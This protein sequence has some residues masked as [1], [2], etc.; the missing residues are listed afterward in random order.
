MGT[1]SNKKNAF[2][3]FVSDDPI[4]EHLGISIYTKDSITEYVNIQANRYELEKFTGKK[5]D[6]KK[7]L[8][9][10]LGDGDK[11]EKKYLKFD[12]VNEAYKIQ[13][14]NSSIPTLLDD[15]E[16]LQI[17]TVNFWEKEKELE[18]IFAIQNSASGCLTIQYKD[19]DV[20]PLNS[21]NDITTTSTRVF[22]QF[23][24]T[25]KNANILAQ[26]SPVIVDTPKKSDGGS[27][28]YRLTVDEQAS[29]IGGFYPPIEGY[30]E[31]NQV[32]GKLR[33]HFNRSL[34]MWESG[35]QQILARLLTD[36]DPAPVTAIDIDSIDNA[37]ASDFYGD[38]AEYGLSGFTVGAALPLSVHNGNPYTF[39]PHVNVS[40]DSQGDPQK[41]KDKIRVVNRAPRAFK[42]NSVVLCSL[43]DSE[44]I[45]Q[46]FGDIEEVDK[47]AGVGG[48]QFCKFFISSDAYFQPDLQ[49]AL[50]YAEEANL[51]QTLDTVSRLSTSVISSFAYE[52]NFRLRFYWDLRSGASEGDSFGGGAKLENIPEIFT[53]LEKDFDRLARLNF[54]IE[55]NAQL[56]LEG[57]DSW[58]E[59]DHIITN[60]LNSEVFTSTIFDQVTPRMG[61]TGAA[62]VLARTNPYQG[63]SPTDSV[64][65]IDTGEITSFWGPGFPDGYNTTQI[66]R[67]NNLPGNFSI[68]YS[69]SNAYQNAELTSETAGSEYYANNPKP[70]WSY[71]DTYFTEGSQIKN[72]KEESI[73]AN[74]L[75]M[76]S[77]SSDKN[78][79]QLPAEIACNGPFGEGV[80]SPVEDFSSL[81]WLLNGEL[82]PENRNIINS[83]GAYL[84]NAY[85]Y[86]WLSNDNDN[87]PESKAYGLEPISPRSIFF[88]FCQ[89]EFAL[90]ADEASRESNLVKVRKGNFYDIYRSHL[91]DTEA[92]HF[93]GKMFERSTGKTNP[94]RNLN[95]IYKDASIQSETPNYGCRTIRAGDPTLEYEA[96]EA[97]YSIDFFNE[98]LDSPFFGS[99][100]QGVIGAKNTIT[101][102]NGGDI[103]LIVTSMFGIAPLARS[104]GGSGPSLSIIPL[105]GGIPIFTPPTPPITTSIKYWGNSPFDRIEYF[106]TAAAYL[107]VHEYWPKEQTLWDPRYFAILHFNAGP[108]FSSAATETVGNAVD[109]TNFLRSVDK[110]TFDIDIRTPTY[111]AIVTENE[112][113][114]IDIDSSQDNTIIPVGTTLSS[115]SSVRPVSEWRIDPIRRGMCLPFRYEY[116]TIGYNNISEILNAGVGFSVNDEVEVGTA[117]FTITEVN[118]EGGITGLAFKQNEDGF[119]ERGYNINPSI[120]SDIHPDENNDEIGSLVTIRNSNTEGE[121][122]EIFIK[123]CVVYTRIAVDAGPKRDLH[124]SRIIP[125]SNFGQSR[126][127]D[128]RTV[129]LSLDKVDSGAYDLF[130]H[131]S[132]DVGIN[133]G[134]EEQTATRSP[135]QY[136]SL[137]IL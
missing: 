42:K 32:A 3:T 84:N 105:G 53:E 115:Q 10:F 17:G 36:I 29:N 52:E 81:F 18:E 79:K 119:L 126:I 134:I 97:S 137:Q 82:G 63:L 26:K 89:L 50:K 68:S 33:L 116:A 108:A 62:N 113:G 27:Y 61:G 1:F 49:Q 91:N 48:W 80:T 4:F 39:G 8:D 96:A 21:E 130:Y 69:G 110:Q 16:A 101:K 12:T 136:L 2:H 23:R 111:G 72:F 87:S 122:A 55:V 19:E 73:L 109:P 123:D 15:H 43:I 14:F 120:F 47:P 65:D 57:S 92:K 13:T 66:T 75:N 46:D 45:I 78:L 129:T 121:D 102:K 30:D 77:D 88:S 60:L 112:D 132:N 106:G 9:Y 6:T 20:F 70:A 93:F 71:I 22:L 95:D 86:S 85:R 37:K 24:S 128:Q 99:Q 124:Y 127:V 58:K 25:K 125:S 40:K 31:D 38:D 98:Y 94:I 90:H 133:P 54:L 74:G 5:W 64:A 83:V 76:F 103:E 34:G 56:S 51:D 104:S 28:S 117:I 67:L 59:T 135:Y 114:S 118:E 100:L 41:K 7:W 35:T 11:R 107:K 44:W 131:I